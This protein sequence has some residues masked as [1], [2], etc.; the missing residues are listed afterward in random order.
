MTTDPIDSRQLQIFLCLAQNGSLKSAANELSLTS[1]AI[2]HS[3]TNL[4]STLG[5]SLFN[6]TGKGLVLTEKGTYLFR[7]A[8]PLLAQMCNVRAS[9]QGDQLSD[10]AN[11]Q[12]GGGFSFIRYVFPDVLREFRDCFPRTNLSVRAFSR[13]A[14]LQA[15]MNREIDCAIVADPPEEN[16]DIVYT[17]LFDDELLL[18]IPARNPM[19]ALELIPIR[20]LANKTLI[21]AR[22]QSY[23]NRTAQ[24]ALRRKG[25]EFREYLEVGCNSA[26]CEMVKLGQGF[27]LVP[28]WIAAKENLSS[29]AV[30]R[31]IEAVSLRRTWA[32]VTTKWAEPSLAQRTILRLCQQ[33]T[34]NLGV[35]LHSLMISASCLCSEFNGAPL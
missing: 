7:R 8:T 2:S 29:L 30:L 16:T 17:R 25:V 10:A 1:S 12:V 27:G 24:T 23:T 15:L 13:D 11:L 3:I 32:Y 9:L 34:Q 14:C 6:R 28:S 21:V 18:L 31:P 26:V 4:E 22:T 33:A 5:V 19:A 20:S 35:A